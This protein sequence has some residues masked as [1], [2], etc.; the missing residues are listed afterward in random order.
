MMKYI[1]LILVF[2]MSKLPDTPARVS[3]GNVVGF[4]AIPDML[5]LSP[6]SRGLPLTYISAS[7]FE[8]EDIFRFF[9]S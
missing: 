6:V 7:L 4:S 3:L 9:N 1:S 8:T 5:H 2:L